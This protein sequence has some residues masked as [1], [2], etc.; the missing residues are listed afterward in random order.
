MAFVILSAGTMT[1]SKVRT[2]SLKAFVAIVVACMLTMLAGGM[3][4][5]YYGRGGAQAEPPV[6]S[7]PPENPAEGRFLLDRIGKLSGRLIRL[8]SEAVNLAARIDVVQDFEKHLGKRLPALRNH[9][10]KIPPGASGGPMIP[11]L[12]K[13]MGE[14][15]TA[16]L[17]SEPQ[18]LSELERSLERIDETLAAIDRAAAQRNL[19]LMAFPSR[20]P[21]AD[22]V[23][24]SRFG[25]R[26]DPLNGHR[27]FHSGL[28][29]AAPTGTPI[30]ASAGGRVIHAGYLG[31]YG[32]A[33]EID[34]GNGLVTRYAHTS[35]LYVKVG[36]VVTPGQRIAAVG[37]TGRS[38]GP[39]LHFE[40]IRDGAYVDPA[41]YLAR[42]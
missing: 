28:D 37:S 32:R 8:E 1:S 20:E 30:F 16:T 23:R 38:T 22:S 18:A 21:L 15:P 34:H 19:Q 13:L 39:H 9:E 26:V 3:A 31:E 36:D 6:S 40:I 41:R 27:A 17:G 11:P 33:V 29:F 42:S 25:N 12:G 14:L 10:P 4:L 5:G 35:R 2:I 7:P 24:T